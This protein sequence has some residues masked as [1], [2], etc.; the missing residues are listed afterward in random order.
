[1]RKSFR[2][3]R[4]L[5]LENIGLVNAYSLM[6]KYG[7]AYRS[8][9]FLVEEIEGDA[10]QFYIHR[11]NSRNVQMKFKPYSICYTHIVCILAEK[12]VSIEWEAVIW[13]GVQTS[14]TSLVASLVASTLYSHLLTSYSI[15]ISDQPLLPFFLSL[16]LSI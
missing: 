9:Q 5:N 11:L 4:M 10:V 7:G 14:T 6:C 15:D 2:K 12:L 16:F 13:C 3:C 8:E 1:M